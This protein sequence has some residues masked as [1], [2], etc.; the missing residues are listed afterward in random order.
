MF[1]VVL[2]INVELNNWLKKYNEDGIILRIFLN[3]YL[4]QIQTYRISTVNLKGSDST[5]SLSVQM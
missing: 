2:L 3:K 1:T 4:S 5:G